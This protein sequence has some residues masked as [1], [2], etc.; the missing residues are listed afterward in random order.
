MHET[1]EIYNK[2]QNVRN[3]TQT[4]QGRFICVVDIICDNHNFAPVQPQLDN[5]VVASRTRMTLLN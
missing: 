5:N 1:I 3:H 2:R 4:I